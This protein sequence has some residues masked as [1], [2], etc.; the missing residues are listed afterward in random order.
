MYPTFKEGDEVL[1]SK[2]A[3]IT[4]SDIVVAR[5]DNVRMVKRIQKEENGRYF[6]AG[7]NKKETFS[8]WVWKKEVIG[9]VMTNF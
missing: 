3:K 8:V 7:D 5:V 4:V 1:V 2:L 9:K 6:L